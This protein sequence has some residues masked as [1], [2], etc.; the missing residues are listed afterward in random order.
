MM[1]GRERF[2]AVMDYKPFDRVPVL[3]FGT[4]GETIPLWKEQGLSSFEAI[5]QETG[6]DEDWEPGFWN[7][8]GLVNNRP[9]RLCEP[10]VLEETDTYKIVRTAMG[11]VIK[12]SKIGA[13]I[14]QHL[15]EALEPT[16][17][18][19]REFKKCLDGT[20]ADRA[21]ADREAKLAILNALQRPAAFLAGSLYSWAREWM[22]VEQWSLLAYDDPALYEEIIETVTNFF[23]DVHRPF[24]NK[25]QMEIAYIHEDCCGRSGPLFSPETYRQF[26]HKHYVRLI[27]FYKSCGVKYILLDSDGVVDPL[28]PCWIESGVDILFPIEVGVWKANPAAI[29]KQYGKNLR[30]MGGVDKHVI[31][32]GPDAVRRHLEPLV[33]LVNEGGYIP[34]PDHRIPPTTS[35][36]QFRDYIHIFKEVFA[37]ADR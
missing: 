11:A 4:W 7:C 36:A 9:R 26:Y 16:R 31:E 10:A 3:F 28:I 27:N 8:H 30:M 24:L 12:D 25:T 5:P 33:P 35:F 14:P 15:K 21:P 2:N 34:M 20:A 23:I 32:E 18:A 19:W 6:M 22:G 29:R 13:S 37:N 17:E 1:N